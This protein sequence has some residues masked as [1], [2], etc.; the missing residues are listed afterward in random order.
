SEAPATEAPAT[1][2]P[3]PTASAGPPVEYDIVIDG[4]THRYG[5]FTAARDLSLKIP[6]GTITGFIGPNGAGKT[7]TMLLLCTLLTPTRGDAY[8]CGHHCV[9]RRAE[10]RKL[11]GYMP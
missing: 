10:A 6:R 8:I 11:L 2:A 7:T 5:S 4:F 9:R 1:E 3:A